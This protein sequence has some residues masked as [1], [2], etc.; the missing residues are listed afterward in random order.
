M[1][2]RPELP[3]GF[4]GS[5][6]KGNIWDEGCRV[7]AFL[8]IGWWGGNGVLFWESQSSAFWFHPVWGPHAYAQCV[9]TIL[10]L[11]GV[12]VLAEQL[13]EMHQT[14]IC[15]TSGGSRTLFYH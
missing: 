9:V 10:H 8:L 5:V 7:H 1:L 4:Q 15:I 6:F 12:L 2:Q 13:K 3:N 11:G 14:V